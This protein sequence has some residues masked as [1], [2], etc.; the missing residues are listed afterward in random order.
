MRY[1]GFSDEFIRTMR[2]HISK[3]NN[4][5]P[6]PTTTTTSSSPST[7]NNSTADDNNSQLIS[8]VVKLRI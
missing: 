8:G 7:K 2:E 1:P 6:P 3:A 4:P 5:A